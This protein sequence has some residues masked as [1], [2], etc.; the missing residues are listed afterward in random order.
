MISV[1]ALNLIITDLRRSLGPYADG[2]G[3]AGGRCVYAVRPRRLGVGLLKA[4]VICHNPAA[5]GPEHTSS[6]THYYVLSHRAG[7]LAGPAR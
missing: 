3:G 1:P 6:S 4:K 5:V 7:W 2:G